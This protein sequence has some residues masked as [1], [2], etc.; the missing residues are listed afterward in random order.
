MKPKEIYKKF[1]NDLI[2]QLPTDNPE[3]MADLERE[4]VIDK[5]TKKKI[6]SKKRSKAVTLVILSEIKKS[7]DVSDKKFYKLLNVMKK[8]EHDLEALAEKIRNHL[9]PSMYMFVYTL[10]YVHTNYASI[11]W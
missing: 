11:I 9:D 3:F 4:G 6:Q 8:Y 1:E 7:L 2:T 5:E 10:L